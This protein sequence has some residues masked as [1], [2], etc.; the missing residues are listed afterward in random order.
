[1]R[2]DREHERVGT[3]LVHFSGWPEWSGFLSQGGLPSDRLEARPDRL[4][5]ASSIIGRPSCRDDSGE[6]ALNPRAIDG[7]PAVPLGGPG[8]ATCLE[9]RIGRRPRRR[10]IAGPGG[11]ADFEH[12]PIGPAGH[13]CGRRPRPPRR[14]AGR[15]ARRRSASRAKGP[16]RCKAISN[17]SRTETFPSALRRMSSKDRSSRLLEG[18]LGSAITRSRPSRARRRV[19]IR[20]EASFEIDHGEEVDA[21]DRRR[22]LVDPRREGLQGDVDDLLDAE[23]HILADRPV[24][25]EHKGRAALLGDRASLASSPRR[26]PG[27]DAG[28]AARRRFSASLEHLLPGGHRQPGGSRPRRS[29]RRRIPCGRRRR[30]ARPGGS[31]PRRR[32]TGRSPSLRPG[33]AARRSGRGTAATRPGRPRHRPA[34]R[35]SARGTGRRSRR[36]VS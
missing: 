1:M 23:A 19:S 17:C 29:P 20:R 9:G 34:A 32:P 35:R 10:A 30:T 8:R 4:A 7:R 25:A 16:I 31:G 3:R 11:S 5:L 18:R 26:S 22:R 13:G 27:V 36:V 6:P 14:H 24:P 15:R 33:S 12:L 21:G 28:R 2:V